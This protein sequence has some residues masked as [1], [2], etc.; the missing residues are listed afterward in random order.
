MLLAQLHR[1]VPSQFE[2]MEDVLTS[3]I[4]G[5]FKYLPDHLA[6]ELLA[7]FAKIAVPPAPLQLQ[8]W[9]RHP[10]PPGFHLLADLDEP[11]EFTERGDTEPDVII[12]TQDWLVLA[13]AKYRSSLDEEYD[14]LGREFA[15]GYRLAKSE[16]RRFRLLV[17]TAHTRC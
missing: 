13:E 12:T 7:D 10:T 8:L 17:V 16:N 11:E 6:G 9:P 2:G 4:F 1:K 14:Q 5:L 3:N 15:I